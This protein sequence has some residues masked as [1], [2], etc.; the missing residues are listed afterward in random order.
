MA[1]VDHHH[2]TQ[3]RRCCGLER[4]G[5]LGNDSGV[6]DGGP[7]LWPVL[8][9]K[10]LNEAGAIHLLQLQ[11]QPRR[12]AVGRVE[13]VGIRDFGRPGQVKHDPRTARH[14]KAVAE[15]LD[16]PAPGGAGS[17]GKPKADLRDIHHHPVRIGQRKSAKLDGL[18]EIKDE[19][20]LL[21]IAGQTGVRG[22]GKIRCHDRVGGWTLGRAGRGGAGA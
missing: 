14:H 16:Q 19:A 9:R 22:N 11:H 10:R 8:D 20:G 21:G 12:L 5:R 3:I 2:G 4:N 18:V 6:C 1:G 17:G 15:R 7:E 13:Q